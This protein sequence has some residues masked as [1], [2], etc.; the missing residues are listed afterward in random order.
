MAAMF[1]A[2]LTF[3]SGAIAY[4]ASGD[5]DWQWGGFALAAVAFFLLV[6]KIAGVRV[7]DVSGAVRRSWRW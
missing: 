6:C 5:P 1:W 7:R 3:T 4:T 2:F